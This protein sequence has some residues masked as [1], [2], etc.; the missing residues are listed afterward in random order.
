MPFLGIGI[1]PQ[2]LVKGGRFNKPDE[3][4]PPE[5]GTYKMG[6]FD[7]PEDGYVHYM[8][9]QEKLKQFNKEQEL[10]RTQKKTMFQKIFGPDD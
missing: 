9:T 8:R 2:W 7:I 10:K 5:R 4:V 6:Q 1:P 3:F